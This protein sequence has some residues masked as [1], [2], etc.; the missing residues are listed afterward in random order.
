MHER[1]L[2][3]A[4]FEI[5]DLEAR[6]EYLERTC[7]DN[8]ALLVRIQR[9]LHRVTEAGDFLD[10]PAADLCS[11]HPGEWLESANA[12]SLLGDSPTINRDTSQPG[13]SQFELRS[14][15]LTTQFGK[16]LDGLDKSTFVPGTMFGRYRIGC[17]LGSGG[18]GVVYLARDTRMG[19][20]VV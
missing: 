8:P 16:V 10:H 1:D 12:I 9:L 11:D 20:H 18:M 17:L 7:T 13:Q 4:A 19:R 2:F 3:I 14:Q 15:W 5:D 6:R